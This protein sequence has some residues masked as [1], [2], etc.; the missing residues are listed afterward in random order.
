MNTNDCDLNG[1]L[2]NIN[3]LRYSSG[4]K[5]VKHQLSI[6]LHTSKQKVVSFVKWMKLKLLIGTFHNCYRLWLVPNLWNKKFCVISIWK[7]LMMVVSMLTC[8]LNGFQQLVALPSGLLHSLAKNQNKTEFSSIL[9]D[10][11]CII[12]QW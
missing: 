12:Y 3:P 10:N 9:K 4:E 2:L 1:D 5:L 8:V 11:L 6:C 7:E